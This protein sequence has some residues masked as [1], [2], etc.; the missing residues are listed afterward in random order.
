[1]HTIKDPS[2]LR[3]EYPENNLTRVAQLQQRLFSEVRWDEREWHHLLTRNLPLN[4]RL[5]AHLVAFIESFCE[6]RASPEPSRQYPSLF[7][8]LVSSVLCSFFVFYVFVRQGEPAGRAHANS[9]RISSQT[10]DPLIP[11]HA[12]TTEYSNQ[13]L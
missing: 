6:D 11:F 2:S 1:M 7:C 9:E 13:R 4:T 8:V 12:V 5:G 10:Q 3:F